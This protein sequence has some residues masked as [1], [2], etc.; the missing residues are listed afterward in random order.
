ML[1]PDHVRRQF[2]RAAATFDSAAFVHAATRDG[3]LSRLQPLLTEAR[4]V[5]DIG[6]ATCSARQAL[7]RRF[8]GAQ[9][10]SL[11]FS[12]RM[13]TTGRDKQSWLSRGFYVQADAT[14]LPFGDATIDVVFSNLLLPWI[15][16]P[17]AV[18]TEVARVLRREGVFAFATLGPDSLRE[19]AAAWQHIDNQPHVGQFPDMHDIGDGLVRSGL[20]GP[21][22]DVDRLTVSYSDAD[23]MLAD[24]RACGAR[25]SL[26]DR[27]PTLTGQHRLA[28]LKNVLGEGGLTLNL[29]LVYG[30]CWGGGPK[31][32]PAAWRVD[33][34]RIP[35]RRR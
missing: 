25:N 32:D 23:K 6:A 2:D 12:H 34:T 9:I 8:R 35:I 26:Q 33:A 30:H 5:V 3:L 16:D 19:L 15:N 1:N 27:C 29:E 18:F 11:D 21:V 17:A 10:V 22:L 13:L 28:S 7:R 31:Q 20:K 24:L 4:T 14:A